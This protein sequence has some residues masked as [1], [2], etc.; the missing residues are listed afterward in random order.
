MIKEAAWLAAPYWLSAPGNGASQQ[1][2]GSLR[3]ENGFLSR[4]LLRNN[5]ITIRIRGR[6]MS[7]NLFWLDG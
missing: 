5:T 1:A 3:V 2:G 7:R 6:T 4:F